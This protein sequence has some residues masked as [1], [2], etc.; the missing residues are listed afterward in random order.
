MAPI[1]QPPRG[2][3]SATSGRP[4]DAE[5]EVRLVEVSGSVGSSADGEVLPFGFRAWPD[6]GIPYPSVVVLLSPS[7]WKRV[8]TGTLALPKVSALTS[9]NPSLPTKTN[10]EGA[11]VGARQI[12]QGRHKKPVNKVFHDPGQLIGSE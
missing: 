8:Q 6:Q 2:Y 1:E 10:P 4:S 11:A 3:L 12:V 7:E 9:M 5:G